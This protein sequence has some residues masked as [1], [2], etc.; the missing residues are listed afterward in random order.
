MCNC[1]TE[2]VFAWAGA[3]LVNGAFISIIVYGAFTSWY[4]GFIISAIYTV[5]LFVGARIVDKKS[6]WDVPRVGDEVAE[7]NVDSEEQLEPEA[8]IT[9]D[10]QS[11]VQ[12]SPNTVERRMPVMANFLYGI[13]TLAFGVTGL[14]LPMNLF[15]CGNNWSTNGSWSTDLS[16]LPTEVREWYS[17]T[18]YG[19]PPAA[20]FVHIEDTNYTVFQGTDGSDYST[21]LWSVTGKA[22]PVNFPDVQNPS[23]FVDVLNGMACFT[24]YLNENLVDGHIGCSNGTNVTTTEDTTEYKFHS[25]FELFVDNESKLWFKDYPPW[26]GDGSGPGT[27]IYS[28]NNYSTMEVELHS[29]FSTSTDASEEMPKSEYGKCRTNQAL[30][31]IFISAFPTMIASLLIWFKRAAP[32]MAVTSYVGIS[33]L[34]IFI[35]LASVGDAIYESSN[36][37][38]WWL[39]ISGAFY[40][41]VLCDLTHCKRY[42]V[43]IPLEWGINFGSL[44]FFV[45]M[46]L[47]TGIFGYKEPAWTWIVFN[48]FAIIPLCVIGLGYNRVFLFVLCAVGWL[49]TA[50]EISSALASV[51]GATIPIY[52]VVLALS[53]MLIACAGWL[54]NKHQEMI[55]E[56]LFSR[57]EWLSLSRRC[58]PVRESQDQQS[59]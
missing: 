15:S 59:D 41:I 21:T 50:V 8:T 35:Y 17:S 12:P 22:K 18:Q 56:S 34:A 52:F 44:A 31:A 27:L 51:L 11:N 7:Q 55:H 10:A 39:S 46:V 53:G 48:I 30:L 29:T 25:P 24:T 47:L 54:L 6:R 45:G 28:I 26:S 9:A 33:A 42:I 58:F 38:D 32:A 20:S 37:W 14:F 23:F 2:Q 57:M 3:I 36:F 1:S 40:I 4:T 16:S 43:Q 13:F 5:L 19:G 49:L